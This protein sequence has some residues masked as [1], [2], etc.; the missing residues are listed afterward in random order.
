MKEQGKL[1]TNKK[2]RLTILITVIALIGIIVGSIVI[3][4]YHFLVLI[5]FL[6]K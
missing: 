2:K 4:R 6:V 5:F 3:K 1:K